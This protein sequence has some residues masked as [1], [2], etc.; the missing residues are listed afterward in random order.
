MPQHAV[1]V[2]VVGV[3]S[4]LSGWVGYVWR[5]ESVALPSGE[6]WRAVGTLTHE[7]ALACL[8]V[9]T[10]MVVVAGLVERETSRRCDRV[11]PA[12]ARWAATQSRGGAIALIVG[13]GGAAFVTQ[14]TDISVLSG[15]F[16]LSSTHRVSQHRAALEL[17][18]QQPLT[19][20]GPG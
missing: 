13:L 6:V 9:A 12:A 11:V 10:A 3:V 20:T 19:G 7:N 1:V 8:V 15:R 4:A 14:Q 18:A 17:L 2:V 5:L 16:S